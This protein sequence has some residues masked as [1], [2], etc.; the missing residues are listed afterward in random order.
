MRRALLGVLFC[1]PA[2]GAQPA[3]ADSARPWVP[4][5]LTAEAAAQHVV[6]HYAP[7]ATAPERAERLAATA[8]RIYGLE[9]GAW[10]FPA[11]VDDGDGRTDL[12]LYDLPGCCNAATYPD[13]QRDGRASASI[14]LRPGAD[15]APTVAHEFFHVLQF[16]MWGRNEAGFLVEASAQWAYAR[17]AEPNGKPRGYWLEPQVPLDCLGPSCGPTRY[18]QEGYWRWPFLEFLTERYGIGLLREVYAQR[19]PD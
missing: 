4:A 6:V 17:V 12:Y 3:L 2:F 11:P 7:A 9:V 16:S 14:A 5:S 13:P 19:S 15:D 10:G 8:E 1:L 18:E